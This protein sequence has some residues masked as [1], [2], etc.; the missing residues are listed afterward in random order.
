[1]HK[2]YY[3][4]YMML[5]IIL[6]TSIL[7]AQT[8][9]QRE[10]LLKFAAEQEI[11]EKGLK[12][13]AEVIATARKVPIRTEYPDGT[14]IEL[15]RF[16]N[17]H[18]VY[19]ITESN[20]NAAKTI[21]TDKV[22]PGG[23]GGF[24]L[25]GIT[26]TVGEWDG[27]KVRNTH[28]ELTGRVILGDGAS[29]LSDHATH[30]AGTLIATGVD[31]A[32]KGMSYQGR[33]RAYDWNSDATEMATAAATNRLRV[34]N[35]SYGQIT[36]W[37]WSY[38]N[39]N[40]WYWFGTPSIS[41]VEDYGFGYYSTR[42]RDWD[43]IMVNAPNYLI[44]KSAG[45]D[46]G[47]GPTGTVEHYIS[48]GGGGWTLVTAPR[49]V[50]GGALGYDCIPYYGTAKNIMTVGAVNIISGGWSGSG[51]V[52]MSS[53]SGWGP[54]DD[55][56][57]KPDIVGAGVGLRSS[58][59]TSDIAYDTYDGTSM[60]SPNITGSIGLLLQHHR[61]LNGTTP[62]RGSTMKGLIIH[63]ADEA[64]SANGPDYRFGWGLM[65]TLKAAQLITSDKNAGNNYNIREM[66]LNNNDSIVINIPGK[67]TAAIRATICWTDPAGTPPPASLN[68]PNPMLVNDLDLTLTRDASTFFPWILNPSN[69]ATA[70][71]TGDNFR[72]NVEQVWIQSPI[73]GNY[74]IKIKHKG[75]LSGGSQAFSL[76]I[77][78]I[79]PLVVFNPR[80]GEVWPVGSTKTLKWAA[81]NYTGNVK[82]EISRNNGTTYTTLIASTT[83]DGEQ[84]W[85]VTGPNSSFCKIRV[86]SIEN[87]SIVDFTSTF[88]SI[89]TP[90]LTLT[91]P[92]GSEVWNVDSVRNIT[93]NSA[94]LHGKV[95]IEITRDNGIAFETLFPE[96]DNDGSEPWIVTGPASNQVKIKITSVEVPSL[97]DISDA[98]FTILVSFLTLT[99]PTGNEGLLVNNTY[100]IS[101][102]SYLAGD[103]MKIELSRDGG[104][105]Y[106]VL[107]NSTPNDGSEQ[108][109]VN[110][111]TTHLARIKIS[112]IGSE[113]VKFASSLNFTI[114]IMDSVL[115][116][117]NW[118]IAS[119]P[120]RTA[121]NRK[122]ILLP[123]TGTAF[124]Y[125]PSS[126]YS[127]ADILSYLDGFWIKYSS[128]VN[129]KFVGVPVEEDSINVY[130]GWNLIGNLS[131]P[132]SVND[133]T[134]VPTS[135]ISAG[136]FGFS[137]RYSQPDSLK[138]GKGYWVKVS[139]DGILKLKNGTG[140]S[141]MNV[142]TESVGKFNSITFKDA[143]GKS[144]TLYFS[145][146]KADEENRSFYELP[147][148][149]PQPSFD[150]RFSTHRLF[151]LFNQSQTDGKRVV[152]QSLTY[153]ISI[154]WNVVQDNSKYHLTNGST[155]LADM[156]GSGFTMVNDELE[157]TIS[158][159]RISSFEA[160]LPTETALSQN[161][162]NPFN[163]TTNISYQISEAVHVRLSVF[164]VLG[165]E[166]AL[167]VDQPQEAGF[168]SVPFNSLT[169]KNNLTSG[170][171]YYKLNAGVK[172]FINKMLLL[173]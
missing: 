34:S 9:K 42:A 46:R 19:Y 127:V 112:E 137:E 147:P 126:G 55:G 168:Y 121:E 108:W 18:P 102:S 28:Q 75:I 1:M 150:V 88:F 136:I 105:S 120:M 157:S 103:N 104:L 122:T 124:T 95:R 93:W 101:W 70:A 13:E 154:A 82:I 69:P 15:M 165:R 73:A 12:A 156:K 114:G 162:P 111:P 33:L 76:L 22:W 149:P 151:E 30:V 141:K 155:I 51:S 21:S 66:V 53:F 85:V 140:Y 98:S 153:P 57:I 142:I 169:I 80:G 41:S 158:L 92:N 24:S 48:D 146:D 172:V 91:S 3:L 167:I 87:P 40:R 78:G 86:S 29:T 31:A 54:T 132:L 2:K 50:D 26:D 100:D 128:P 44:V 145:D 65:N 89:V 81:V 77:S 52:V 37:L 59:A 6:T 164:D 94:N 20:L 99:F 138:P 10:W 63:T 62:L 11:I 5:I 109:L 160:Q 116:D 173:K 123:S 143:T 49:N 90:S 64:G 83:N 74:A 58:V 97:T 113:P 134:S 7:Q 72:D 47:E 117:A 56:R 139:E 60:S 14:I 36:G 84:D 43:N 163:P 131:I 161:Y 170:I 166:V 25:T 133:I 4:L 106:D 171:Y 148:L 144:Q 135:I 17:N 27:G 159:K 130:A 96:T 8:E 110:E 79:Q 71:T 61:N 45:N 129:Q 23:T 38:F 68:P 32:A 118:N 35:H 39:D 125:S 16:E 119:I 152:L 115:Y 67:E 107:F